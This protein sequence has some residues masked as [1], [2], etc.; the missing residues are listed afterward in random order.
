[1]G[2][3]YARPDDLHCPRPV[4]LIDRR[5]VTGFLVTLALMAIGVWLAV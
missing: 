3:R 1:M 5:F 4:K 2:N